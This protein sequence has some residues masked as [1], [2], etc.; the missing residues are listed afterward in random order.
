MKT[1]FWAAILLIGGIWFS[2][3]ADSAG[4]TVTAGM[5]I[6]AALGLIW[7]RSRIRGRRRK[8]VLDAYADR[9]IAR[10][11]TRYNP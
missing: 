11:V 1:L 9:E 6:M 5:V 3:P 4:H 8:A 2:L 10:A 7:L